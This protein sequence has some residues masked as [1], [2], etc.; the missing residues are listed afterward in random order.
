MVIRPSA[1]GWL[2]ADQLLSVYFI[3]LLAGWYRHCINSTEAI[4]LIVT[5]IETK[6]G[7]L[8]F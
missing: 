3:Y 8:N 7:G 1:D 4:L 2:E 5:S 6:P